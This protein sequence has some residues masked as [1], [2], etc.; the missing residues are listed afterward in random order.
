MDVAH[1]GREREGE[2]D[3][4]CVPCYSWTCMALSLYGIPH[5]M[6]VEEEERER[7]SEG[8]RE[9]EDVFVLVMHV[10]TEILYRVIQIAK[11]SLNLIGGPSTTT[12][13]ETLEKLRRAMLIR[14]TMEW[15][16]TMVN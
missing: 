15:L 7:E 14:V 9:K 5:K 16:S 10:I 6:F 13:L 2:K 8:G 12:P 4:F 11:R 3:F 1:G